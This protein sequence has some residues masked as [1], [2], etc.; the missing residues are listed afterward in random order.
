MR[1]AESK[2]GPEN[3]LTN[4]VA[5]FLHEN[6]TL[7]R[8]WAN[9]LLSNV[10]VQC[11][12]FAEENVE[13]SVQPYTGSDLP[14]MALPLGTDSRIIFEHKL[15]SAEGEDQVERYL[16]LCADEERKTGLKHYLA[17]V[18]PAPHNLVA[19]C[20]ASE[21][22]ITFGDRHPLWSDLGEIVETL[23]AQDESL[24]QLFELF[25]HLFL[26]PYQKTIELKPL[27]MEKPVKGE[28]TTEALA[29]RRGFQTILHRAATR[30]DWQTY[31]YDRKISISPRF[32]AKLNYDFSIEFCVD[33]CPH[34]RVIAGE[35]MPYP[36]IVLTISLHHHRN[37]YIGLE[38]EGLEKR[39]GLS[40]ICEYK[41]VI[42]SKHKTRRTLTS[43]DF[44]AYYPLREIWE[45]GDLEKFL[46]ELVKFTIGLIDPPMKG[47]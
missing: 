27:L 20:Y 38:L 25:K 19:S 9:F 29:A 13:T 18:A 34:R 6:P 12:M 36:S 33:V 30:C 4:L 3:T 11:S 7:A 31:A 1:A 46:D 43:R 8:K 5:F 28:L 42:P 15:D 17:F 37:S 44:E 41:P 47:F 45:K 24:K 22:F 23:A 40:K 2:I 35:M 32:G 39:F 16:R 21:R 26:L 14:D 10:V